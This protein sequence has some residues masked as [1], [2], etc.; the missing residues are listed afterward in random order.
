MAETLE[1]PLDSSI[2]TPAAAIVAEL[3]RRITDVED[4]RKFA[5][6]AGRFAVALQHVSRFC[7]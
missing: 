6:F 1:I 4:R 7:F 5:V 3:S 2:V